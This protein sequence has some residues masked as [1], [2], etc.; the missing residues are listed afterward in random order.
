MG[1]EVQA[2]SP[3]MCQPVSLVGVIRERTAGIRPL[4][5]SSLTSSMAANSKAG[6]RAQVMTS[7]APM[8]L[9]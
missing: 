5:I 9:I 1:K 8:G 6:K 7:Q 3:P 2:Y 4:E